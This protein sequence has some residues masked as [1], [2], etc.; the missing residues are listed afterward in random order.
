MFDAISW[1]MVVVNGVWYSTIATSGLCLLLALM[2]KIAYP[3]KSYKNALLSTAM[4]PLR[5]FGLGPYKYGA[6][7]V[8]NAIK[9]AH[10]KTKLTDWGGSGQWLTNYKRIME[11]KEYSGQRFSNLGYLSASKELNLTFVRRLRFENYLKNNPDIAK[12][13]LREPTF[14]MGLPRTGTTFL[15]RLLAMD[16]GVRSPLT[17]E[18]LNPVPMCENRHEMTKDRQKRR[19][20]IKK[21]LEMRKNLGDSALAHIHEVGLDLPEECLLGLSDE[22]PVQTQHLFADYM[23]IETFLELDSTEAY[24][25]YRKLLQ[26]LDDQLDGPS[27]ESKRWMLKCPIHLFYPKQIATAFP[28]AKLIWTHRDPLDAVPSMCSLV[29]AFHQ[30]YFDKEGRDDVKL[31]HK[32][33]TVSAA[34][35]RK[36][37]DDIKASKLPCGHVVYKDLIKDPKKVVQKLYKVL[38]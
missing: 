29:K 18:L 35:L 23:N 24:R 38:P 15:H 30:V 5:F 4:G 11:T 26:L 22:I 34:L 32:I 14:V 17:W 20:H 6:L 28:D 16:P 31:G 25:R 13:P 27:K 10:K 36:A 7:T 2:R 3:E 9:Y 21:I 12:R 1:K 19:G 33:K 37:P 8:E